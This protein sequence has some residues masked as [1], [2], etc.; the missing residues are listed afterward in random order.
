MSRISLEEKCHVQRKRKTMRDVTLG[1]KAH[2]R[3]KAKENM[4]PI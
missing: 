4:L 1:E 3:L 2:P